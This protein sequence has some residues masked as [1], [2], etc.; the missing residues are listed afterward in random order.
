MMKEEIDQ[1]YLAYLSNLF[2][3]KVPDSWSVFGNK[4]IK[5]QYNAATEDE[6][7]AVKAYKEDADNDKAE[8]SHKIQQ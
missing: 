6:R 7:K 1:E 3:D 2:S 5:E 8:N 4:V